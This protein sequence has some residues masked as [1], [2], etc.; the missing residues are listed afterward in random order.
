MEPE[1]DS[2]KAF[3]GA[4]KDYLGDNAKAVGKGMWNGANIAA[5]GIGALAQGASNVGSTLAAAPIKGFSMLS[6]VNT[7]K[8]QGAIKGAGDW[9]NKQIQKGQD[10]VN[11]WNN[12][13]QDYYEY[14]DPESK[15]L[16]PLYM[17]GTAIP[18]AEAAHLGGTTPAGRLAM[19]V[20]AKDLAFLGGPAK[21]LASGS[22]AAKAFNVGTQA[23][24]TGLPMADYAFGLSRAN[25]DDNKYT[26]TFRKAVPYVSSVAAFSNPAALANAA[27]NR[28]DARTVPLA[29]AAGIVLAN[30]AP[31]LVD[32]ERGFVTPYAERATE[33]L[34]DVEHINYDRIGAY[35][36][37]LLNSRNMREAVDL[38]RDQLKDSRNSIYWRLPGLQM[39]GGNPWVD[40]LIRRNRGDKLL[41][42]F[43]EGV[44]KSIASRPKIQD[45]LLGDR[46]KRQADEM[47][48]DMQE[49]G[50]IIRSSQYAYR[51]GDNDQLRKNLRDRVPP[52]LQKYVSPEFTSNYQQV[53][54]NADTLGDM[55]IDAGQLIWNQ[56][57]PRD[58]QWIQQQ[59]QQGIPVA[60]SIG[61]RLQGGLDRAANGNFSAVQTVKDIRD[62]YRDASA[63]GKQYYENADEP[64]RSDVRWLWDNMKDA[65][66]NWWGNHR[67]NLFREQP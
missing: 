26:E 5:Q 42:A 51:N 17:A 15:A 46:V 23:L 38:T 55:G 39:S 64:N 16:K 58:Q 4:F 49:A 10:T 52:L 54:D 27:I 33:A 50:N 11:D 48:K 30:Q 20:R 9:T 25:P 65:A 66:D 63:W 43:S 37:A 24:A 53:L 45:Y 14:K 60:E 3:W 7:D 22:T 40:K 18:L 34:R 1:T 44:D 28:S 13:V 62:M 61:R 59:A 56:M 32:K 6:G 36:D 35:M 19:P 47:S 21:W 57:D 2:R 41:N 67:Q 29:R 31:E 12:A 8:L